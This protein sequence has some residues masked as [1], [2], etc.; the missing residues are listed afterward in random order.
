MEELSRRYGI[1]F[2]FERTAP[3]VEEHGLVF[4]MAPPPAS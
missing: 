3:I 4:P 1:D 2:D